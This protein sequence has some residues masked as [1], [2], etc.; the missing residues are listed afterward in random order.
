MRPIVAIDVNQSDV[1]ELACIET[2]QRPAALRGGEGRRVDLDAQGL[3]RAVEG[4]L[5]TFNLYCHGATMRAGLSKVKFID[6][7]QGIN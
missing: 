7:M 2:G 5:E 6:L 4:G 1:G 3:H